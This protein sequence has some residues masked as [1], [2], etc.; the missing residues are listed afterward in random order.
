MEAYKKYKNSGIE[1]L[2]DVPEHWEVKKLKHCFAQ[3]GSGTTPESG[4]VQYYGGEIPW[5]TTSELRENVIYETKECVTKE[6]QAKYSALKEY[7]VGTLLFAMYGATI[8][9]LA[10]LGVPAT[11]NQACCAFSCPVETDC[12]FIYYWLYVRRDVLVALSQGGGQPNLSQK[13]LKEIQTPLPPFPE[14][15]AIASYLDAKCKELDELIGKK[16]RLL[17]LLAEERSAL[18]SRAVT[19]GLDPKVKLKDSGIDWLGKVPRHWE[20]KKLKWLVTKVGSGVTPSGG[21]NVYLD[22]GIPLL[23]SQNIHSNG[24][25]LD[26]VAYI[27]KEI[28]A[29]M[30]NSRIETGDVLLNITGA[31]IGRCFYVPENFGPGNVNQHVCI[32]RPK[33]SE[34]LT[35]FLHDYIVSYYGQ[36][37]IDYKQ[38]GANREGLNFQQIRSFDIPVPPLSEQKQIASHI[39]RETARLDGIASR[40]EREIELLLEYRTALISEAVTGKVRIE[41]DYAPQSVGH[42]DPKVDSLFAEIIF[43]HHQKGVPCGRKRA[44]KCFYLIENRLQIPGLN[45][46]WEREKAGPL[47][48][49]IYIAGHDCKSNEWFYYEKPNGRGAV[50]SFVPMEHFGKHRNLYRECYADTTKR[51]DKLLKLLLSLN[52][53][54]PEIVATLFGAWNDLIIRKERISVNRIIDEFRNHWHASKKRFSPHRLKVMIQWMKQHGLVPKGWGELLKQKKHKPVKRSK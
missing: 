10:V 33:T 42:L 40:T 15:Q 27:S 14:Q 53:D 5:V 3:I 34:L 22:N 30:S 44:T 6:A 16:R 9:R 38:G 37:L 26:D 25:L 18:I 51:I 32:I 17:E 23:R 19:Q 1:W 21:A 45:M 43:Q 24:L 2:G 49:K 31:S 28:D 7:P 8:G 54:E 50:S 11:V 46:Y 36:F 39:E 52:G 13:D 47:S 20:V 35:L 4:N 48:S 12:R 41:D 29:E